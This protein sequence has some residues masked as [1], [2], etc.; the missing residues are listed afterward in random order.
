MHILMQYVMHIILICLDND[1]L[2]NSICIYSDGHYMAL[3][4]NLY[5]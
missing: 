3:S 2:V 4:D 1:Y 5:T